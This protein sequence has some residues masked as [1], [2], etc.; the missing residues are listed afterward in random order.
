MLPDSDKY[1]DIPARRKTAKGI[2]YIFSGA[3]MPMRRR[4]LAK[5]I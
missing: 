5:A 3:A 1:E 4:T 2:N